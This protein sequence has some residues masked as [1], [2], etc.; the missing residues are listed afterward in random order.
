VLGS[1]GLDA[2]EISE[3]IGGAEPVA[4]TGLDWPPKFGNPA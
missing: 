4:R 2:S 1:L 3:A